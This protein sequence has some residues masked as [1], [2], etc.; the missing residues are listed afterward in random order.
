MRNLFFVIPLIILAGCSAGVQKTDVEILAVGQ[1]VWIRDIGSD[2][3]MHE[4]GPQE[5][6][7]ATSESLQLEVKKSGLFSGASLRID[8]VSGSVY[9]ERALSGTNNVPIPEALGKLF[10]PGNPFNTND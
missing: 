10:T 5:V 3:Q 2:S 4:G 9:I 7:N 8:N 1:D 6:V